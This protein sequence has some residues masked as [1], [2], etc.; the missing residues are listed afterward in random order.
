MQERSK[1]LGLTL[2]SYNQPAK[3]LE[4]G[5]RAFHFPASPVASEVSTVL[6]FD[7]LVPAIG[8]DQLDSSTLQSS[9]QRVTVGGRVKCE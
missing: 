9:S 8:A 7:L 2:V 5:D 4:P 6:S 3:A 1:H